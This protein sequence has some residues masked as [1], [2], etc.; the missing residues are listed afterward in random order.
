[1]RCWNLAEKTLW[2]LAPDIFGESPQL[3]GRV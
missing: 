1:M 2:T 3:S